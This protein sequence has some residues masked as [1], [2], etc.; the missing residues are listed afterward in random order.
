MLGNGCS[1]ITPPHPQVLAFCFSPFAFSFRPS[2]EEVKGKSKG[3]KQKAKIQRTQLLP[4]EARIPKPESRTPNIGVRQL[5]FAICSLPLFLV[6]EAFS[7]VSP[8]E[9]LSP[10]LKAAERKYLS[11]LQ[12]LNRAITSTKFPFSF[13]VSR[14]VGLDPKS[15]AGI[16]TRGVEFVKFHDRVVLK[17]S[18]NYNA[19]FNSD[20]L[21]QNQRVDR[22][23]NDVIVPILSLLPQAMPADVTCDAIGFEISY[24]VQTGGRNYE[25]EGK[26]I[27]AVVLAKAD[28]FTYLNLPG[29]SERQ[30]ILNR[31]GVYVN[32]KQFGLALGQRNPFR[33]E[34][35]D[36][37]TSHQPVAASVQ[38]PSSGSSTD[39]RLS[40]INQDL[41]PSLQ[42]S[43]A[44]VSADPRPALAASSGGTGREKAET[45]APPPGTATQA[46]AD[47][48]QAKHQLQLDALGKEGAEKLH[49][50]EYA[51]PDFVIFR[52][53][54]FLQLTLRNPERFD[55]DASSIY[56]R[57]AQ[58]FDLFLAPQLKALLAKAPADPEIAG[59]DLT[60]LN[61]LAAKTQ[62]S[63]EAIEFVCP[64]KALRQFADAEI[65]SQDVINQSVVL[66]NGV[67]IALNLQQVE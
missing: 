64:L 44:Q 40:T 15:Q 2:I 5:L 47:R 46:D 21:T 8:A 66:V 41:P 43:V 58:S 17:I 29:D 53:Q 16:D 32:G 20:L 60:V 28:A 3:K 45:L 48:L 27:L 37:P 38:N 51:P 19:A 13:V 52:N 61:Q 4:A 39:N 56:K 18:G 54:V 65:T 7:Q 63:S 9:I 55:K 1:P 57:A 62:P 31:S 11:Q 6:G 14:Y 12:S 36:Q 67:R 25:Y 24:H 59:L 50:A 33:L 34:E 23:F 10:Q 26:E 30:K 35:L 22:V 49:L 42:K